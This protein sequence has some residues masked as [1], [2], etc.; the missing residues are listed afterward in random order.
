[1]QSPAGSQDTPVSRAFAPT[2]VGIHWTDHPDAAAAGALTNPHASSTDATTWQVTLRNN[3]RFAN[4]DL[5]SAATMLDFQIHSALPNPVQDA[6][7]RC[8]RGQAGN[9]ARRQPVRTGE[10]TMSK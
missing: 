8:D 9:L 5:R 6:R 7:T 10:A 3:R 2:G 1:M 4:V